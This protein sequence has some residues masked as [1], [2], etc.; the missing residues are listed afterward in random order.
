MEGERRRIEHSSA[1]L[2]HSGAL[3]SAL[4]ISEGSSFGKYYGS[5]AEGSSFGKYYGSS[6]KMQREVLAA[7]KMQRE[8][9]AEAPA[10]CQKSLPSEHAIC[11]QSRCFGKRSGGCMR[12]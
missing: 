10:D 3:C 12:P 11:I 1:L 2:E 7:A 5:S 8:E 9:L 6:A 4:E